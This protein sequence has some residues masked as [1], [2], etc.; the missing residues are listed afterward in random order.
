MNCE[1][2]LSW[3]SAFLVV[4]SIDN[5]R[6]F[7]GGQQYL[8]AVTVHTKALQPKTPIILLGNKLDME[9]YRCVANW[10]M[11]VRVGLKPATTRLLV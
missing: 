10:W 2:Y 1:C 5:R 11:E 6:S 8:E 4:Y 3:A 7:E 9:R